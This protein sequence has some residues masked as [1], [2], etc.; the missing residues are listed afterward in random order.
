MYGKFAE[1]HD[2]I[3]VLWYDCHDDVCKRCVKLGGKLQRSLNFIGM[4][5]SMYI[6]S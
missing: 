6:L 3:H 2:L 1:S 5:D 4:S